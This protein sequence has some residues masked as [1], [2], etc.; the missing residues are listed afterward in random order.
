M[1]CVLHRQSDLWDIWVSIDALADILRLRTFFPGPEW[2]YLPIVVIVQIHLHR[3]SFYLDFLYH[4]Q[5][6]FIIGAFWLVWLCSGIFLHTKYNL[7]T[8]KTPFFILKK[9]NIQFSFFFVFFSE[10]WDHF[11]ENW[12]C[13]ATATSTL[14]V[15]FSHFPPVELFSVSFQNTWSYLILRVNTPCLMAP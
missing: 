4:V 7:I 15:F 2:R 10:I 8:M 11:D 13:Y 3:Q 9:R 6:C 1:S 14:R 5:I 12:L